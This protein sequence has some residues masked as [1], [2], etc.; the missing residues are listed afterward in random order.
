MPKLFVIGLTGPTGAGKSEVARVWE[1]CGCEIIDADKLSRQAVQPNTACFTALVERFSRAILLP[2]GNLNRKM[3]A[4]LAFSTP[5]NTRALN[6]IVHPAVIQMV[7]E[8]LQQALERGQTTV[9]I[10]AP[11]LF[12]SGLGERCDVTVAVLAS[13]E[14]RQMRI[15]KRDRLTCEEAMKRIQVQPSNEYYQDRAT[16]I[17]NNDEDA[18]TLAQKAQSLLT[19]LEAPTNA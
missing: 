11:L 1:R 9:V 2:D 4:S 8:R 12:E 10:D 17:L 5:E 14:Q 3:L 6:A 15:C 16:K 7:N 13:V 18:E 19:E